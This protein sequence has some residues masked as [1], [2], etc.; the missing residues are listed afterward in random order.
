M[1][2]PTRNRLKV[3]ARKM[4]AEGIKRGRIAEAIGVSPDLVGTWLNPRRVA[5]DEQRERE[6]ANERAIV[7]AAMQERTSNAV[8]Q[9]RRMGEEMHNVEA[10]D[11]AACSNTRADE[12]AQNAGFDLA[13]SNT[14]SVVAAHVA[15]RSM[16]SPD[17]QRSR[18]T[19]KAKPRATVPEIR[20]IL[21]RQK[22]LCAACTCELQPNIA[23]LDHIVP[24][25]DGGDD[26][27]SNLQWLCRGCN[28]A[29]AQMSMGAFI[30]MC[31][32]IA[33]NFA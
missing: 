17:Q 9:P 1:D 31:Q 20:S 2:A 4:K 24:R 3:I 30:A 29:K 32:R 27:A 23:E 25:A 16:E 18:P 22:Y 19:N 33:M 12:A 6:A 11:D 5:I 21:D 8:R 28:R 26:S 14:H 13:R 7:E 15:G 10:G